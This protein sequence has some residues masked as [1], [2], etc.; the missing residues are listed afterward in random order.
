MGRYDR[1]CCV[2]NL[3]LNQSKTKEMIV[4][5]KGTTKHIPTAFPGTIRVEALSILGVTI[6]SDLKMDQHI[7]RVLSSASSSQYALSTLR[8][9]GLPE[10][11]L[12]LV[13][14]ATTLTSVLYAS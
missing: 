7:N 10:G 13:A 11:S 1:R 5:K 6:S 3:R 2:I 8:S 9:R 4:A 12:H 14:R